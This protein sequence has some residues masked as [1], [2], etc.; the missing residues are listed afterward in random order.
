MF[1]LSNPNR[2]RAL[3]GSFGMNQWALHVADGRAVLR[4]QLHVDAPIAFVPH[5]RLRTLPDSLDS[6]G[7]VRPAAR[8]LAALSLLPLALAFALERIECSSA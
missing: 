1:T 2:V 4:A 3:A 6:A 7:F 5:F 8:L